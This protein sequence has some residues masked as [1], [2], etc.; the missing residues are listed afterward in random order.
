MGNCWVSSASS[1]VNQTPYS[2]SHISS[3]GISQTISNTTSSGGSNVSGN[4]QFS[5][6]SGGSEV[7]PSVSTRASLGKQLLEYQ[8]K[9]YVVEIRGCS[10][11]PLPWEIRLKILIGAARGLTFLHAAEKK[12]TKLL[13]VFLIIS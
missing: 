11:M 2:T 10:V 3:G 4:S 6:S 13:K 12:I 7:C 5:A 9:K 1:S 8:L